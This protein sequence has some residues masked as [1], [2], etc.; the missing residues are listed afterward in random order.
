MRNIFLKA[1]APLRWLF[2]LLV[3]ACLA[4][5]FL[6]YGSMPDLSGVKEITLLHQSVKIA[7][8]IQGI[9]TI[10]AD[11]RQDT[12]F[13]LGYVHAQERYFQ[14][15][16]LRRSA[17]GELAELFG[18]R[19]FAKDIKVR[20]HRFRER[21]RQTIRSLPKSQYT[22]LMAY[23]N[24]V[25][26]GINALSNDPYQ[27]LLLGQ[28]P[29]AWEVED[30]LLCIYAMYNDLNDELGQRKT[31]L[32]ILKDELPQPWF[33]FL[34]P[35]GGVWDAALD[36]SESPAGAAIPQEKLPESLSQPAA[37]TV[38][39]NF[40]AGSNNWAVDASMT[41]YAA[42]MLANDMHLALRV[43]NIWFRA[44]WYLQDGRRITGVTLPGL[45]S[46]VVGSNENIAWGFTNSYGDWDNIIVLQTNNEQTQYLSP[47]GWQDF[48]LY[49]HTIVS[50][51]GQTK[52]HITIETQWGPV[53]GK[54]HKGELLVHQWLAYAPQA[55]NLN[56]L[57][58]EQSR[59]LNEALNIAATMAMPP[60]NIVIADSTGQIGW[61][62]A[63][64]LPER[65]PLSTE[66]QSLPWRGY[67]HAADYP[68]YIN[69]SEHRIWTANNRL[70]AG[71]KLAKT[72]FSGGDIGARA[73]QIRNDLQAAEH[74]SETDL[75]AIQ[76]DNRSPFLQRWRQL[77]LA[78]LA[79]SDAAGMDAEPQA[80][81]PET[82]AGVQP[83]GSAQQ[84]RQVLH[85]EAELAASPDSIAYGLVKVFRQK[86]LAGSVGWIFAAVAAKHPQLFKPAAVNNMLE[87]PAW[88]LVSSR[89]E[90]LIPQG[91]HSW[92]AFLRAMAA[93][94]YE[95]ITRHGQQPLAQQ[96]WGTMHKI[97]LRHPLSAALPGLGLVLDMPQ[98]PLSG[99]DDMPK[100]L[101]RD[102]GAS[103]R[104]V[105]APGQEKN[106][107][108]HMPGGQSSHPLSSYY[109]LGH[110]DWVAGKPSA[111]LPGKTRW[112][113]EL[114]ALQ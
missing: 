111:F 66:V 39:N 113:L 49:K 90:H 31:S 74:F 85:N 27:Y 54:N 23:T 22:V 61:T 25:N 96:S 102:F 63:G 72:G 33:D 44:S 89:P 7:R 17:A 100:V 37:V 95:Q 53:I 9:P 76:L 20:L 13:A 101:G 43:P 82:E 94:S 29:E 59:A 91:Y 12:A 50:S 55:V 77:M 93:Q 40:L 79:D 99:D 105:V 62:I 28:A 73:Q 16:L 108:M 60:Q 26:T 110:E 1:L 104:M 38:H 48:K 15:D 68:Q 32:A 84:M 46:M 78:S 4:I 6:L 3:F 58:L 67:L 51:S 5:Y 81:K 34:S 70:F 107:I 47:Q 56:V 30:S 103:M 114:R 41:P 18:D 71:D 112:L 87:Y 35:S 86:V 10:Y 36:G 2:L 80:V 21:A 19:A 109:S 75:L 98:S 65:D 83:A 57:Q 69:P 42:A 14:M 64:L 92:R 106:A 88:A 24:G 8:D 45:P 11:N 97:A 52:T